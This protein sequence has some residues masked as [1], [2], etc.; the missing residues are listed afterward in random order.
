VLPDAYPADPAIG[1]YVIAPNGTGERR[2]SQS[3]GSG[4]APICDCFGGPYV[5]TAPSWS[6]DGGTLL[7]ATGTAGH[8][9]L[10]IA[11]VDGSSERIIDLPGGDHLLPAFSPDGSR[12][13]FED[14][15]P[16]RDHATG[17]VV[18]TDGRGLQPLSGGADFALNPVF[19]SPDGRFVVTYAVD[20]SEIHLTAADHE[21]PGETVAPPSI[22]IPLGESSTDGF[23]ERASWQR[24]AP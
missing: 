21:T 18:A 17:F 6:P 4:G 7:Y 23:P 22:S 13:A 15:A 16:T 3:A 12:I 5:G 2:V 1:V 10:A 20:L 8:H 14:L 19:W 11:A 24:L 9:A